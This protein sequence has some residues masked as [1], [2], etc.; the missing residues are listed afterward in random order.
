MLI[1]IAGIADD[2][3]SQSWEFIGFMAM[4]TT[5]IKESIT[6]KSLNDGQ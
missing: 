5:Q 3:S 4:W 1:I 2:Y 6:V